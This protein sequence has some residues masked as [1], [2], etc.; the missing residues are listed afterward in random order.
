MRKL[1]LLIC[2]FLFPISRGTAQSTDAKYNIDNK[3]KI[4]NIYL[5]NNYIN[6]HDIIY[7]DVRKIYKHWQK[8][9]GPTH[10]GFQFKIYCAGAPIEHFITNYHLPTDSIPPGWNGIEY[11]GTPWVRNINR[12]FEITNG[13]QNRHLSIWASHGRYFDQAKG[14]WKFQRPLLFETTEDLFTQTIV[15]PY[16]IPMLERSGANVFSPRERDWQDEEYI[17]DND[18]S[19]DTPS[20]ITRGIYTETNLGGKWEN[21]NQK[22][23]A[24]HPNYYVDGENP[25]AQGTAKYTEAHNGRH[26][27]TITYQPHFQSTGNYAVYVSYQTLRNSVTDA[28]YTVTHQGQKTRFLVNQRMGGGT[29][30]YLGTFTFD[31]GCSHLNNVVLTNRSK[32]KGIVSADAVRFG[33]GMGNIQRYGAISGLPRAIEGAR[34]YAQWAGAPYKVYSSKNGLDDYGDDINARPLMTNWLSGGS[35]YNPNSEGLKIPIELALAVHSDAGISSEPNGLIGSLAVCTTDFNDG[36][37]SSGISRRLSY[38]FAKRLL[39]G[40][41]RDIPT[42][43]GKWNRRYLWDRNY[44]ETR[45]PE[46]PSAILETMSHQNFEDMILGEDPN[47]RFTMARSIYKSILRFINDS[48]ARPSI[49]QPLAPNSFKVEVNGNMAHLSWKPGIDALEPTAVPTSYNIYISEGTSGV[50]NGTNVAIPNFSMK[51]EAGKLYNFKVTAVNRGGESFATPILSAVY[52]PHSKGKI[53]IIDGFTRLSA[54]SVIKDSS[55]KRFDMNDDPGVTYGMTAQWYNGKFIMGNQYND[56][57]IHADAMLANKDY[58]I[59]SCT[60]EVLKDNSVELDQYDLIDIMLGLERN[61]PYALKYYKT[62]PPFLQ[63]KLLTFA[64]DSKSLL[65][66]GAFIGTDMTTEQDKAFLQQLLKIKFEGRNQNI[67]DPMIHGLQTDFDI[68]RQPNKDHYAATSV[69]ILA[70]DSTFTTEMS[71]P[72]CIMMYNDSTSAAV[73]YRGP[74]YNTIVMG[75]PFETITSRHVRR[76]MM[77]GLLKFALAPKDL[78][79]RKNN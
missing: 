18:N 74:D 8:V 68:Y 42:I 59:A 39:D 30:V 21:T 24:F 1:G 77:Q 11:N 40:L 76:S 32:E 54:P 56:V 75:F 47:F 51:L 62:F 50:D 20:I 15:I 22:G 58:S 6:H 43:C 33:G 48:H 71:R 3:N 53:L 52:H 34:Y 38:D 36:V 17:I 10:S 25:F 65:I 63:E 4:I 27:S 5:G 14:F 29:W 46:I 73:G 64:K 19:P 78:Y 79:N 13:L 45:S 16:L 23:F 31:A 55:N 12:P 67:Q 69:D 2:V 72:Q 28:E 60:M 70:P 49:V 26:F 66:S 44:A 37:L 7:K 35:C 61:M 41:D 9:L 57:P